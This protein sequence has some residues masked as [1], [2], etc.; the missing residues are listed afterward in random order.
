MATIQGLHRILMTT[1]ALSGQLSKE[2]SIPSVIIVHTAPTF[3]E[4][5][6]PKGEVVELTVM[7]AHN[8][9]SG[10]EAKE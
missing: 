3:C 2:R 6:H 8:R 4:T 1:E 7:S 10:L 5:M 9:G